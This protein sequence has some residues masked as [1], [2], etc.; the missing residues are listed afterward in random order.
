MRARVVV[1]AVAIAIVPVVAVAA[2]A[3]A[4]NYLVTSSP[5]AGSTLETLP[6]TFEVTTNDQLP[7]LSGEAKGFGIL[8]TD[9]A[10]RYYGDGCITVDGA[11]VSTPAALGAPGDYTLTWQVVST[12]GHSVSGTVPFT[13]TGT[14]TDAGSETAP[15]CDGTHPVDA[16][17]VTAS[18]APVVDLSTVLWII[19]AVVAVILAAGVTLLVLRPRRR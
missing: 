12:D 14:S 4:H 3:S 1:A 16:Q 7:D 8:V 2:P 13:W 5:S 17:P 9:A 15:D 11:S 10:G 19:G 6:A 18:A